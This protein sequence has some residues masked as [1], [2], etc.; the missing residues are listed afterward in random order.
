MPPAGM[1]LSQPPAGGG[2]SDGHV[3]MDDSQ[4]LMHYNLDQELLA[5]DDPFLIKIYGQSM[6]N[7][8]IIYGYSMD[9]I[10]IYGIIYGIIGG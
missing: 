7:I 3:E 1:K 5:L 10:V 8:W 2:T 9:D 6:G 4:L